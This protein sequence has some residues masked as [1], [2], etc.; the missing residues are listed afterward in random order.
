VGKAR[1]KDDYV[2]IGHRYAEQVVSGEIPACRWVRLACQRQIDDLK[3][4]WQWTFDRARANRICQFIE[5]LPHIKGKWKSKTIKLEP[6]QC[7]RLTTIFGWVDAE[8]NRRFRKA[9]VV[10][11][12]KNGKTTEAAGVGL[13]CLALDG[14]PGAEVYAGAVTRDQVTGPSGVWNVSKKLVERCPGFREKFGV[15][16]LAHSIVVES[17]S[18][19][20]K[21]ASRDAGAQE[22]FNTH[23]AIIDELHA[24]STREVF[25]VI[26]EST[27]ARS[28]PLI[29]IIS[30]EGDNP[31]GVFA[32]QVNYGEMVL[33]GKHE[34]DSYFCIVYT[35]DAE[36]DWVT[37]AAWRKANP[38]LGVSVFEK[39]LEVRCR[40]AQ[41]NAA[42]QASF[43]AK[44]LNVRV[45]AGEAYFSRIAWDRLC[46]DPTLNIADLYG[47]R[48]FITLDLASKVDIAAKMRTIEKD[49]YLYLFG[50]YYLPEAQLEKGN[51]NYDFYRGWAATG[52]LTLTPGNIIDYDY[53][54]RDLMEDMGDFDVL[55]VGIDPHNATQFNTHMQKQGVPIV[56]VSQSMLSL[57]EAMKELAARILAARVRH[58]GNPILGWMIGNVVAKEDE[59]ENVRPRKSRNAN[60]IDGALAAI[61]GMKLSMLAEENTIPYSG[62]RVVG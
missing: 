59:K 8:G 58:D 29:Y 40:Q 34:D 10:L 24:H 2:S 44:R 6:H 11:P 22:G 51:P 7:F 23:C 35:I 33:E 15:E 61:M 19:S 50:D 32:E 54:E 25:D 12:R 5:L 39:D 18:A 21:P 52:Q 47:C 49:G 43:L 26:D 38:N 13:Y 28:Q 1:L 3:R 20:F 55:Q 37:P 4:D 9:L 42:S 41:K 62:L 56:E 46:G 45:G 60:K 57:S 36:D 30:T 14:E 17:N 48:T 31:N 53:I 27:G 16:A